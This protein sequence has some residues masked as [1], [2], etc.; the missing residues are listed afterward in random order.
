MKTA[1]FFS[2]HPVFSL[3]EAAE[4]LVP[5]SGRSGTVERLKYH[6]K[7]GTLKLAARGVYAVVPPGVQAEGFQ[8]DPFLVASAVRPQ[9]VFS[10]HSALEL[11]GSAHSVWHQ[12][13]L[14]VDQRRRPLRL[15]G[16]TIR[17]LELPASMRRAGYDKLGTLRVERQGRLLRT[18]GPE[19]TL[20]EG[21]RR[22]AL[23]GGLE[24]LV[25]SSSGFSTLDL[26]LLEQVLEIYAI[27]NLWAAVGWFL[28]RFQQTFYVPEDVLDRMAQHRP[29]SPQYLERD[30]RGGT[31]AVRWNLILPESLTHL[32][33]PD[34]R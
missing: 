19:R 26:I 11:L 16:T 4:A 2:T 10:H 29:R 17:F 27:A 9:G 18:T 5:N 24:E 28:E 14:Y 1:E 7:T 34:E 23:A 6:L 8:P 22:P 30:R 33:E 3:D 21:F 31:L 15:N 32:E 13:T 12:C 25:Q 20:V